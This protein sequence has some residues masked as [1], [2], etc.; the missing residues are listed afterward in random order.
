MLWQGGNQWGKYLDLSPAPPHLLPTSSIGP[1]PG[2]P[3][4]R[5]PLVHSKGCLAGT[6]QGGAWLGG[7]RRHQNSQ[8]ISCTKNREPG[9]LETQFSQS[10]LRG[11]LPQNSDEA[12][13]PLSSDAKPMGEDQDCTTR[14]RNPKGVTMEPLTCMPDLITRPGPC[15]GGEAQLARLFTGS[16]HTL[17]SHEQRLEQAAV[18]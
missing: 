18:P 3:G 12:G 8:G 6:M 2:N 5:Q 9:T 4:V 14:A 17:H 7:R 10:H 16:P 15:P 13:R 1:T 11:H